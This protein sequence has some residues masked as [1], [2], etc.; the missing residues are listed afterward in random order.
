MDNKTTH[1]EIKVI[2]AE[3]KTASVARQNWINIQNEGSEGYVDDSKIEELAAELTLA[4][5]AASPL[6]SN[7]AAEKSWFNA[8]GFTRADLQK[9]QKAC[10]ARG[11]TV[12]E[13][14]AA[15]K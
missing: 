3:L 11:Y 12:A 10:L 2:E 8:Q 14:M 1:R 15:A 7:L 4:H 5:A 13:L 9:A 6:Q